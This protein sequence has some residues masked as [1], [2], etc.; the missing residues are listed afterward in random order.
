MNHADR[1]ARLRARFASEGIDGLLVTNL[2]NVRYLTGFSGTNGQVLVTDS[3]A[4]FFSD[5][6]YRERARDVV[7]GAEIAIYR[8]HVGDVLPQRLRDAG[9]ARLGI[10]ARTATIAER[11]RLSKAMDGCELVS[12]SGVVE[13]LRRSKDTEEVELIRRAAAIADDAFAWVLDRLA[14]GASERRIALDLE[15]VM[16]ETGAGEVSFPPIVGSGPLSAHIHHTA[17]E[18]TLERGDLVL[19]DVGCAV[20]GYC[21]DLTRT[22]SLGPAAAEHRDIYETVLAAQLTGIDAVAAGRATADVDAAA[23]Q[24]VEA[25]SRGDEFPHGVGHGVGL[26]VHEAP[27]LQRTSDEELVAGDVVTIEPG[28]YVAGRGGIRIEDDVLVTATGSEVLTTAPKKE[29]MEL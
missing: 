5:A 22:V 25:A 7:E 1:V 19:L 17:G 13:D 15:V 9:I 24:V 26:E 6:R 8:Q 21:S 12:T 18:R 16:R 28:I 4:T 11:D 27:R 14:P 20:G 10:E 23:R 3:A 29:L 2:T